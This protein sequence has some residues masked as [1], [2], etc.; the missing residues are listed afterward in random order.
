MVKMCKVLSVSKNGYYTWLKKQVFNHK[1]VKAK[2]KRIYIQ[3]RVIYG[4]PKITKAFTEEDINVSLKTV[5][6]IMKEN[7]IKFKTVK[8]YKA[9]PIQVTVFLY[10]LIYLIKTSG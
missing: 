10:L 6:N 3:S 9:T 5:A 2:I 4:S 8:K 7:N 1:R